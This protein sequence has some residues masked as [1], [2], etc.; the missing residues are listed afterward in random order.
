M[1]DKE[2]VKEKKNQLIELTSKFCDEHLDEDYK[3]LCI[4]L[5]EKMGRK[6]TVPF[7]SGQIEIWAA[8]II[9]AIGYINFLSDKSFEPY[10][11]NEDISKYFGSTIATVAKKSKTIREMFRM[12]YYDSEFSTKRME[13][14]N[15]MADMVMINGFIVDINDL[16][17]AEQEY[18]RAELDRQKKGKK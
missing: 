9:H 4:K 11:R 13:E 17:P 10:M 12:G 3:R 18:V 6:R 16:S 7:L 8:S 14:H 2:L 1:K 5:I 15:P